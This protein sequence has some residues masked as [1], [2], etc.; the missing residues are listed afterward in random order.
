[1]TTATT[2]T[3]DWL[4]EERPQ[5]MYDKA[6]HRA[7]KSILPDYPDANEVLVAEFKATFD[8]WMDAHDLNAVTGLD[9]LSHRDIC[10]G[11]TQFID[12][13]YQT[14]PGRIMTLEGDYKYHWRL[15]NDIRYATLDSLDP[16]KELLIAMPFPATGDV[17]PDMG[18]ILDRCQHL[19]IPVHID[20][21]WLGASKG[22][23]F[24]FAH[25]AIQ[26]AAFSLSK[27]LG[28]GANRVALRY[29][30]QRPSGPISI[31]NDF[32]MLNMADL[33]IG[34]SFMKRFG[35]HYFWKRY[36]DAYAKVCDDFGLA[37]TKTIHLALRDG[38]PVG[39]RP[40][41]R[42]LADR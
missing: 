22:I 9:A 28:L 24:D 27:G 2:Y 18:A 32:N 39:V 26:S 1:M 15:D 30:R 40:L 36:G 13:L 16:S 19:G 4:Q 21:A 3:S 7:L 38:R 14:R 31:M 42:Y 37:P 33:A 23:S 12:D 34:L 35:A 29:T 17:H 8:A 5:P 25:P 11:C 10:F 6:M 41:L 20:G